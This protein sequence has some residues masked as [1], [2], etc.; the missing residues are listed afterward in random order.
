MKSTNKNVFKD[1]EEFKDLDEQHTELLTDA[2]LRMIDWPIERLQCFLT[3][4][5]PITVEE[6]E[7]FHNFEKEFCIG[8]ITEILR[9]RRA[10]FCDSLMDL[11]LNH[12]QGK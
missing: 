4:I 11:L 6:V 10:E 1:A 3:E 12:S 5:K 8:K 2:L 7:E 9:A